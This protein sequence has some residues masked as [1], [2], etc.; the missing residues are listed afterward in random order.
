M[1]NEEDVIKDGITF[2]CNRCNKEFF[3][4]FPECENDEKDNN[5]CYAKCPNCG[6]KVGHRDDEKKHFFH[7]Y[8]LN[9]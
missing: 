6:K 7:V 5:L 2:K 9:I 1:K 4:P 3:V 8:S